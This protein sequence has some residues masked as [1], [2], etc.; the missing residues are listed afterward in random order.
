MKTLRLILGD[1][2]NIQ[3]SW[4]TTV[5]DSTVYCMFEMRQETDYVKHHIQKVVGFFAAMRA[6]SKQL[7]SQGHNVIYLNLDDSSN[8]QNLEENLNHL[9]LT[10]NIECFQYQSP[11]EFR[12][13]SQLKAFCKSISISS[14]EID[15]E[16]FY[17]TR[18]ELSVFFEGKKQFLMERFYRYMRKKHHILMEGENPE[19][20]EWNYDKSNRNKWKGSPGIPSFL[21]LKNP[22]ETILK[23][24]VVSNIETIGRF[25]ETTFSYP[26]NKDQ[27]LEQ[28]AY[29]N[30]NLLVH[31]GDYQD[32]LHTE[33]V[34]LFHSRLSFAMNLKLISP[35]EIIDAVLYH[36]RLNSDEISISQVEGFIRQV[37]GWRE[38]MR[39]MYWAQM[40]Q[41]KALNTLDNHNPIPEF[42]WTGDTKM[43]CLNKTINNSLDNAYAH[44]IQR[45][46]VLGNFALLS[47]ID[48]K[49][50]NEWFWIVYADAYQWVELPNVSGMALFAD[51]GLLASK[52]YAG[53]GTYIN[54]MSN[55]CKNC[56]F[57][58]SDQ[59]GDN[60]CP[61]NYLYW[62]FLV[63]NRKK[64]ENNHRIGMMYRTY[65][66]LSDERK[67]KIASDSK[68][69]LDQLS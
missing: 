37:I 10:H 47:S 14:S 8:L 23:T 49:Q 48:P 20:G 64:L 24:I 6:F 57:N 27:S 43:N 38:Y 15:T 60:A 11:D 7:E 12:L 9:I 19:G 69:F 35:K 13:D 18:D 67:A 56:K 2:L 1:Q 52:P 61:F 33:E 39:G 31:F 68:R 32:A 22:V 3:H 54:K 66:K 42:F 34:Y 63:R 25:D 45:L 50:V 46:M 4:Y 30:Q 29:F 41:Y 51:G 16:H 17:T 40:P 59:N 62:D 65:D 36:Y 5:S 58:V 55:Y 53:G 28:L 26:I 44:H 21:H